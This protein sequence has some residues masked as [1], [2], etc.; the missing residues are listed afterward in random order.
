MVE[1]YGCD[2]MN[3]REKTFCKKKHKDL[4]YYNLIHRQDCKA[5]FTVFLGPNGT[6]KSMSLRYIEDEC[7]DDKTVCL[8]YS[9]KSK[10]IVNTCW[11]FDIN[12][13]INTFR[14]EG[15]RVNASIFDWLNTEVLKELLTHD[16]DIY[17][18][19]DELDSG[20]SPNRLY[21]II[22][23]WKWIILQEKTR[24]PERK[25]YSIFACNS[26]ELYEQ[27][28]DSNQEEVTTYWL[29][30]K[31]IIKIDSYEKFKQKYMDYYN[32]MTVLDAQENEKSL[33]E[34]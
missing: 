17:M 6:G 29:P 16:K 21:E 7:K 30:S 33:K 10:D 8:H 1:L 23:Q 2:K 14:S 4:M 11:D 26:Y 13:M 22:R 18:L 31:S 24:H 25:I 5:T 9:N 15:E 3:T 34:D 28:L 19:F 12:K 32:F 27:I 20:L